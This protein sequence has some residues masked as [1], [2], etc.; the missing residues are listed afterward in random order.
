M[1]PKQNTLHDQGG[2]G[3]CAGLGK[4]SSTPSLLRTH[5]QTL[6]ERAQLKPEPAVGTVTPAVALASTASPVVH[7]GQGT[8]KQHQTQLTTSCGDSSRLHLQPQEGMNQSK[9]RLRDLSLPGKSGTW[10]SASRRQT[11]SWGWLLPTTL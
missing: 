4:G 9:G 6:A 10:S 1:Q 5:S 3:F 2:A 7:R 8:G 11:A